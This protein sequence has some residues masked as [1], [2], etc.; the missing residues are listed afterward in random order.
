M[1]QQD[2][3]VHLRTETAGDLRISLIDGEVSGL[4]SVLEKITEAEAMRLALAVNAAG[5]ALEKAENYVAAT[6]VYLVAFELGLKSKQHLN[7]IAFLINVGL[8][9]KRA[10]QLDDAL[11]IYEQAIAALSNP[12]ESPVREGQRISLLTNAVF[13]VALLRLT[14]SEPVQA[15]RA[16]E[17]CLD[18]I[19]DRDDPTSKALRK[20]CEIVLQDAK[21]M[22]KAPLPKV[23][24]AIG[25]NK[26]VG[27]KRGV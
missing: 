2:S 5:E 13:N 18:L 3:E 24:L 20:Q 14:R 27:W 11:R 4:E 6:K 8:S 9:Q 15:E 25:T 21:N 22:R 10:N 23:G 19:Q 12:Q 26:D 7:A 1:E 16:A 17:W